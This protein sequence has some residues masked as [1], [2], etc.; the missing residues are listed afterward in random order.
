MKP[1]SS[2]ISLW[3][4]CCLS[5]P[6]AAQSTTSVLSLPSGWS[7]VFPQAME[8]STKGQRKKTRKKSGNKSA[9]AA[10]ERTPS[11]ETL[12]HR[13]KRLMRECKGRPNAGACSGFAS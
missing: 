11:G 6:A 5:V 9:S 13:E 10:P 8:A 7:G 4:A 2:V 1:A 12:E 3:F